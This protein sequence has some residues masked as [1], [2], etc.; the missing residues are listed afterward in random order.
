MQILVNT[1]RN[2]EGREALAER[3]SGVVEA[4]LTRFGP[5]I[6][7]VE[8]HLSDENSNKKPGVDHKRCVIEARLE[9]RQPVAVSDVAPTMAQAVDGATEKL[10][11]MLDS[12]FGKQRDLRTRS[13]ATP[14]I[15]E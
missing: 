3:V 1:D 8:I 10:C 6:T 12:I 13:T 11:R 15:S 7:R 4:A 5:H 14:E 9:G 2:V